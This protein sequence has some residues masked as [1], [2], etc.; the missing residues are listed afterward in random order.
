MTS[1]NSFL[2]ITFDERWITLQNNKED[3]Y[4]CTR[5]RGGG[6][7]SCHSLKEREKGL[8]S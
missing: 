3:N 8:Y 5:E 4:K 6:K 2:F 7:Q 1:T